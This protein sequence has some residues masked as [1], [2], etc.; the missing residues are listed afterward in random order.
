MVVP[1]SFLKRRL[2]GSALLVCLAMS[3]SA[4]ETNLTGAI[5][6]VDTNLAGFVS[7]LPLIVIDTL[8]HAIPSPSNAPA[9]MRV[10]DVGTNRQATLANATQFAGPVKIKPRGYTSLRNPKKSFAVETLDSAGDSTAVSLLGM[11]ADADWILY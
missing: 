9:L 4:A 7:T 6:Q 10:I 2:V 5:G 11:P 1:K 8:G 3:S